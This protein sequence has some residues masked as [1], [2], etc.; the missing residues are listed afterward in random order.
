[1]LTPGSVSYHTS[2]W[3]SNV[4]MW[5]LCI[6]A[7]DSV[8][9]NVACEGFCHTRGRIRWW[10][11]RGHQSQTLPCLAHLGMPSMK[12]NKWYHHRSITNTSLK[13]T[14]SQREVTTGL[15]EEVNALL[16]PQ[17]TPV[18]VSDPPASKHNRKAQESISCTPV[19]VSGIVSTTD[20]LASCGTGK[21]ASLSYG[22][23]ESYATFHSK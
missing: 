17:L 6:K 11:H 13:W 5:L 15:V 3:L 20:N 22:K 23:K 2:A 12:G 4:E 7:R 8:Q 10:G 19:H 1:M 14:W 21:H 18:L 9:H 16:R